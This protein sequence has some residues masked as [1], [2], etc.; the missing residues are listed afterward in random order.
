[1][2][3]WAGISRH[4]AFSEFNTLN[5]LHKKRELG[6]FMTP[7][8]T[9][10]FMANLFQL[11]QPVVRLLDAGAGAGALSSAFIERI[12]AAPMMINSVEV[13]AYEID[14]NLQVGLIRKLGGYQDRLALTINLYP[15][16]F[17]ESAVNA[18]QFNTGSCFTH[19]ILNPPYRKINS[20]S[21][22]RL[23]LRRVGIETVNL[24][25]AFVA[26]T[27]LSMEI[28]GQIVAIIPRSFCNGPYYRS[29]REMILRHTNIRHIHLFNM[30]NQVFKEDG[31]LQEN[32]IIFIERG[33]AQDKVTIST[34]SDNNFMDY[35]TRVYPFHQIVFRDD[36]QNFIHIPDSIKSESQIVKLFPG[37]SCSLAEIGVEVSTG[38]VVDFRV[39]AHLRAMPETGTVPLI[40]PTHFEQPSIKWPKLG[41]KKP[42]ALMLHPETEKWLYPSG[43]YT[44]VR[45]FSSKEE[46]RRIVA[47][48]LKPD[49]FDA[50]LIGFENHLNIFHHARSGLSEEIAYGLSL[51]LNSTAV[52]HY[53]RCFNGHTQ[54]NATDLRSIKYPSREM[55]MTLGKWAKDQITLTQTQIDQKLASLAP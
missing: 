17:I 5:E 15:D 55:L 27:I 47:T 40:Y 14:K 52:D 51:F 23:L 13:A 16:D 8:G 36:P 32:I 37:F 21:H 48:I 10:E 29:F 35:E 41:I 54:V 25:S 38:P 4:Q 28:G 20:H 6:Q 12:I 2:Y 45:R 46:P 22:H 18:I 43:F 44:I 19:A 33:Q 39:K 3:A 7:A 49:E 53:F 9:A 30:R 26:L 50:K 31:V 24:Y 42:N 11:N 1:L 34:S